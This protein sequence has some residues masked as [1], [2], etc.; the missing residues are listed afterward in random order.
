MGNSMK[1]AEDALL[2]DEDLVDIKCAAPWV[3]QAEAGAD[4][5]LID[6]PEGWIVIDTLGGETEEL[7]LRANLYLWV[8]YHPLLSGANGH[9]SELLDA[10]I[11]RIVDAD[12]RT[13]TIDSKSSTYKL[14]PSA[15]LDIWGSPDPIDRPYREVAVDDRAAVNWVESNEVLSS[16]IQDSLLWSLLRRSRGDNSGALQMLEDDLLS[17]DVD[18]RLLLTE[19][20]LARHKVN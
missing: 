18:V 17:F 6:V 10:I 2:L 8:G 14:A 1:Y 13:S 4:V 9:Q 5:L 11:L 15:A 16:L 3:T 20:I 19:S 7:C 12:C